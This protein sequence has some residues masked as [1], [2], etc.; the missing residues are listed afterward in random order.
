MNLVDENILE[1]FA[2]IQYFNYEKA[3]E[4]IKNGKKRTHWMWYIFPQ[5][6]GLGQSEKSY[7]YGISGLDEARKYLAHPVLGVRLVEC[8]EALLTHKDKTAEEIFDVID[9]MKLQSSMT[10]FA[11]VSENDSVF[12]K[13]LEQFFDGV[14]D[15]ETLNI[16]KRI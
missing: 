11:L 5:L 7:Y 16:I 4:E 9:D 10:L 3:Y 6:R 14:K 2:L 12:H 8:C 15:V 1:R 13:V